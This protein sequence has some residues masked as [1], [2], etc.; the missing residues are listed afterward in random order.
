MHL[1][2]MILIAIIHSISS[3]LFHCLHFTCLFKILLIIHWYLRLKG[4]SR[5]KDK[6]K[7]NSD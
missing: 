6:E 1:I 5:P 7:D 3:F 4:E 2:S